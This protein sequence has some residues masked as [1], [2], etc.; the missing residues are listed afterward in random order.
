MVAIVAVGSVA[1]GEGGAAPIAATPSPTLEPY[2]LTHTTRDAAYLL[3]WNVV[4]D[5]CSGVPS[6]PEIDGFVHRGETDEVAPGE[7]LSLPGDSGVLWASSRGA[8][9]VNDQNT[10]EFRTLAIEVFFAESTS[11][12]HSLTAGFADQEGAEIHRG[13]VSTAFLME[14]SSTSS[15]SGLR[16]TASQGIAFGHRLLVQVRQY[17]SDGKE[18]YCGADQVKSLI[19]HAAERMS[20]IQ[21]SEPQFSMEFHSRFGA[22]ATRFEAATPY[23]ISNRA[24]GL[25]T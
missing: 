15:P 25:I 3:D 2:A 10:A 22:S 4:I 19:Q 21:T 20:S 7:T 14:S 11:T 24:G 12:L 8:R 18:P 5:R 9:D 6:Q 1:C 13:E 23:A 17:A 16:I